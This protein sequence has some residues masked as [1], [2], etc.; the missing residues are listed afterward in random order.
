MSETDHRTEP[1]V[2]T[3]ELRA[4]L[5]PRGET[6]RNPVLVTERPEDAER[7]IAQLR[8]ALDEANELRGQL[9]ASRRAVDASRAD[10][11]ELRAALDAARGDAAELR[12]ELAQA[13]AEQRERRAAFEKLAGAGLFRRRKVL[14]ELRQRGIF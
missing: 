12:A 9:D 8:A 13:K 2:S 10:A 4:A 14:A 7:E 6:R 11:I 1:H 5:A 3:E